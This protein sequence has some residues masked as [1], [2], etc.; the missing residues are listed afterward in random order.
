MAD[1]TSHSPTAH[2]LKS[3]GLKACATK[4]IV[5]AASARSSLDDLSIRALGAFICNLRLAYFTVSSSAKIADGLKQ[6][7][8]IRLSH[9]DYTVAW[10]CAIPLEMAAATAM[11]DEAHQ[12]LPVQSNDHN[13]YALGRI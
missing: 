11:L 1:S 12:D 2:S 8:E 4:N 3:C 7:R 6:W 13:S 10:I 5:K 9:D